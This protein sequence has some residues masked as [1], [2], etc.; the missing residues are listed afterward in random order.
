LEPL[1]M[2]PEYPGE[3]LHLF[4]ATTD[5]VGHPYSPSYLLWNYELTLQLHTKGV[6]ISDTCPENLS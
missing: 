4:R 1:R 3:L 2:L 5:Y 6:L